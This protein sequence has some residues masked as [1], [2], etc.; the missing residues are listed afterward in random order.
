MQT[1]WYHD[2][3]FLLF[4]SEPILSVV[5]QFFKHWYLWNQIRYQ[6][7]VNGIHECMFFHT[8]SYKKI[9]IFISV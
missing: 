3:L 4:R 6:E 1:L 5:F 8:L 2:W 7:T 9:K